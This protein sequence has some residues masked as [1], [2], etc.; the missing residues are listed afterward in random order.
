MSVN[1][2][3]QFPGPGGPPY[4]PPR[5]AAVMDG[6]TSVK[7]TTPP[8]IQQHSMAIVAVVMGQFLTTLLTNS[9]IKGWLGLHPFVDAFVGAGFSAFTLVLI[10]AKKELPNN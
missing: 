1:P 10:Y 6:A 2:P 5:T 7:T 3:P 8:T 4:E 9:A